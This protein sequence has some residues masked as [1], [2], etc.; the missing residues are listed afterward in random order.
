MGENIAICPQTG[1]FWKYQIKKKTHL[2][3]QD[4]QI[5]TSYFSGC[6]ELWKKNSDKSEKYFSIYFI[7]SILAVLIFQKLA[8]LKKNILQK[9]LFLLK[10][11]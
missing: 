3:I 9:N 11:L 6:W 10:G 1:V 7:F 5:L 8:F 2:Y 4:H